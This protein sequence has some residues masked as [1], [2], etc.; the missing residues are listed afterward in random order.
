MSGFGRRD[1][2]Q[3]VVA[4]AWERFVSGD[5][6]PVAV[7]PDVVL[8][9]QR[10][11]DDHGL[12]WLREQAPPAAEAEEGS[13]P[14]AAVVVA[15]LAGL[16]RSVEADVAAL[17]GLAAVIDGTGR[18][19]AAWGPDN[20]FRRA[21]EQNFLPWSTW[22]EEKAGTNGIALALLDGS[23]AAISGYEHWCTGFR[24][25]SCAGVAVRDPLTG[26]PLGIL[27]LSAY[28]RPIPDAMQAWMAERTEPLRACLARRAAEGTA[29]LLEAFA[30]EERSPRGLLGV[31]NP[32]GRLVAMTGEGRRLLEGTP[33]RDAVRQALRR[34][35]EPNWSG[36][37]TVPTGGSSGSGETVDLVLTPV[38]RHDRTLGV[39]VRLA[40]CDLRSGEALIARGFEDGPA[41][42]AGSA[43]VVAVAG[44]RLAVLRADEVRFAEADGHDV[45][46]DTDR[47][48]LRARDRGI[49][50]L[51]RRL[52]TAG[53]LRVHR[54]YLVNTAR[55]VEV[56]P[57]F[58]GAVWLTLDGGPHPLIP[59][60]S[61]LVGTLWRALDGRSRH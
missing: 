21:A 9:W 17:D 20:A 45:W 24:R 12:D 22:T 42:G 27:D 41:F 43:R 8:S 14:E 52:A 46:L 15:E 39:V 28:D 23:V 7:R 30:D 10:C 40:G 51:E 37:L 29:H 13:P 2:Q 48:R 61:R 38:R 47:G 1:P 19:L 60:S 11:R 3:R 33:L 31:A 35:A 4:Q 54:R 25:W 26:D 59:V 16:A 36:V 58:K 18:V 49:G 32:G 44:D 55:I 56:V 34:A 5:E 53:F 6:A 57:A 50:E